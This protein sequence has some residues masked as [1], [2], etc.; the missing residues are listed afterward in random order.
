MESDFLKKFEEEMYTPIADQFMK[1]TFQSMKEQEDKIVGVLR[2]NMEVFLK[3]I[4]KLQQDMM[5]PVGKIQISFLRTSLYFGKPEM[6]L[7]A[8]DKD[9]IFGYNLLSGY[10]PFPYVFQYWE[11]FK[12]HLLEAVKEQHLEC[13]VSQE[14]I[15]VLMGQKIK[16]ILYFWMALVKYPLFHLDFWDGYDTVVKSDEFACSVGEYMD[17]QR[18]VYAETEPVDIFLNVENKPLRCQKYNQLIYKDKVFSKLELKNVRFTDCH[19]IDCTIR[20]TDFSDAEFIGCRF[21]N[22]QIEDSIFY[23]VLFQNCLLQNVTFTKTEWWGNTFSKNGMTDI[24]RNGSFENTSMNKVTFAKSN[25]LHV[26][27]SD[28]HFTDVKLVDCVLDEDMAAGEEDG[29]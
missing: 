12:E 28:E 7:D 25:L 20:R 11:E 16:L 8:Y 18:A 14:R 5:L 4:G 22:V 21:H 10:V 24:F 27:V 3:K 6:R 2:K 15:R 29:K 19:F 1:K 13:Y 26:K 23:G 9:G 17:W